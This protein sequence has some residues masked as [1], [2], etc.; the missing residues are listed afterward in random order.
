MALRILRQR[1]EGWAEQLTLLISVLD[2]QATL[3]MMATIPLLPALFCTAFSRQAGFLYPKLPWRE[4]DV[5]LENLCASQ[6]AL[7]PSCVFSSA[8]CPCV[9]AAPSCLESMDSCNSLTA[10][11]WERILYTCMVPLE[12]HGHWCSSSPRLLPCRRSTPPKVFPCRCLLHNASNNAPIATQ[13]APSS[14]R[15]WHVPLDKLA[16]TSTRALCCS[17]CEGGRLAHHAVRSCPGE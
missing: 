7:V 9:A 10:V 1:S 6:G 14:A 8:S 15:A 11:H 2:R 16:A 13:A 17:W 4:H 3:S 5:Y 12:G